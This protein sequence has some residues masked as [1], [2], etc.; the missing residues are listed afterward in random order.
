MM[1]DSGL[2][3]NSGIGPNY[4]SVPST[5]NK[6]GPNIVPLTPVLQYILFWRD[7]VILFPEFAKFAVGVYLRNVYIEK[8]SALVTIVFIQITLIIDH[9]HNHPDHQT[10][11]SG[12]A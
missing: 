3:S 10:Q 2:V 9:H 5:R 8:R 6:G 1:A 12:F 7:G 4:Q 11:W